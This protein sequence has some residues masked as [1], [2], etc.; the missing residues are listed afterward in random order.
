MK[1]RVP[2]KK[3]LV[4][5]PAPCSVTGTALLAVDGACDHVRDAAGSRNGMRR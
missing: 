4:H 3:A 1:D 5:W 2:N